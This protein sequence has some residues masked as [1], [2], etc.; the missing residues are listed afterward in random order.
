MMLKETAKIPRVKISKTPAKLM[1]TVNTN[2]DSPKIMAKVPAME[3]RSFHAFTSF[4]LFALIYATYISYSKQPPF[5]Y[6]Y[7]P[8]CE[9]LTYNCVFISSRLNI[10]LNLLSPSCDWRAKAID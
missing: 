3:S 4:P 6:L 1:I 7:P 10:D 8:P 2:V 5:Y 9:T